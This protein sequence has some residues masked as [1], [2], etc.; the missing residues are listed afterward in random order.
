MNQ[1]PK[2]DDPTRISVNDPVP[3]PIVSPSDPA[4]FPAPAGK[5]SARFT[6]C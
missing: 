6:R 4:A 2:A 3:A 1:H 5:P